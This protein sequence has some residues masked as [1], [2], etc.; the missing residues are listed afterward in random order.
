MRTVVALGGN[1]L[2]SGGEG[3]VAEMQERLDRVAPELGALAARGH[4]LLVTHGNGPQVGGLLREQAAAETPER[5][6]DVLVA[7]TQA[8]IGT[9]V[10]RALDAE[11]DARAVSVVTHAVVDPDDDAFDDPAKPVGPYLDA[12]AAVAADYPTREVETERGTVH[13]R[14]VPSPKPHALLESEHV[15][16]LTDAGT[17]VVCGGGGGVPVTRDDGRVNGVAAV[18]DK[19]Y[20]AELLARE[21]D[22]DTLLMVT[23]VPCAYRNYNTPDQQPIRDASVEGMRDLLDAGEFE[24]GS[25][26]PKVDACLDFLDAGGERAIITTID[27]A[28]AA[29]DGDAGTRIS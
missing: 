26:R 23:D 22:A 1:A 17:P 6:L 19:D 9:L 10:V 12:D 16:R 13:R 7:E 14:V 2:V 18:V 5:P 4:D 3:G 28:A 25:M 24:A 21:T 8:Q 29:V 15:A 27:G 11:L 20:T